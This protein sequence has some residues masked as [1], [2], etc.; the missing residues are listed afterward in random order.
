VTAHGVPV[1]VL[2]PEAELRMVCFHFL[3]HGGRRHLW[4][5]DIAA[6]FESNLTRF[7]WDSLLT[8]DPMHRN[9]IATTLGIA[10][11][12]LGCEV[13]GTPIADEATDPPAWLDAVADR[14]LL[15]SLAA[16]PTV[17]DDLLSNKWNVIGVMLSRWPDPLAATLRMPTK[18]GGD[19]PFLVQWVVFTRQIVDFVLN[20]LPKQVAT[21]AK[22]AKRES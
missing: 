19:N 4:L 1:R 15:A 12:V 16:L 14:Q 8:T 10:Y 18:F 2:Q 21:H 9:W 22:L 7:D 5:V 11:R 13:E 20:R 17:M 6:L 3:K